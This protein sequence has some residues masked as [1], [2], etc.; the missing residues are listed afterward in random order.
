[1]EK[2]VSASF[3][4]R[5]VPIDEKHSKNG[6]FYLFVYLLFMLYFY[7]GISS[8]LQGSSMGLKILNIMVKVWIT[9]V[10]ESVLKREKSF[11]IRVN[12]AGL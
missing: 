2:T 6:C 10:S 9:G 11:G 3:A 12:T 5:T 8:Y 4:N 1:N 7:N